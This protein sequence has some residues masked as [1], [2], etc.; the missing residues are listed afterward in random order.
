MYPQPGLAP[1][2]HPQP[3]FPQSHPPQ[4]Y[5]Q[6]YPQQ[7]AP[8]PRPGISSALSGA[9][10]LAWTGGAVTLLGVVLLLVLAA[11]RDWFT[12]PARIAAGALLAVALVAVGFWLYRRESAR[13]GAL[14][15]VATGFATAYLVVAAASALYGYL[16]AVPAL[17]IAL[18]VAG[19]GLG[20][21]DRWRTQLL[22]VAATVGAA[23]LAPVLAD[24]WLLVALVLALQV[25]ALPVVLRR[26]WSVL[27]LVAAAGPVVCGI[28]VIGIGVFGTVDRVVVVAVALAT[29]AVA[30]GTAVPAARLLPT[31]PVAALA[32]MAAVPTLVAAAVLGGWRGGA[33]AAVAALALAGLAFVP[34]IDRVIRIVAGAAASVALVQATAIALD[35][36]SLTLVVLGE[37]VVAAVLAAVLRS[38]FALVMAL[39]Y[40]LIGTL[41]AL[42]RDAPLAAL[43]RFPAYPYVVDGVT[44]VDALVTGVAVSALLLVLAGVL[45][46]AGGR[47]GWIR[48]D[49]STAGLWVPIGLAG[50]YGAAGIVIPLALLVSA[51]RAGFTAGHA[52]V[53]VSWTV[54]ALVLLARGI[55]RSALR[56]AGLV[57]VAAA[58]AKLVLF[59]LVALDGLARVGAFLGAGLVLLAAGSRYTRLAAEAERDRDAVPPQ[60]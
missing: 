38:R 20:V 39:A 34:G 41:A 28:V 16:G 17:F 14:A 8:A 50:L 7:A 53:T 37:A 6:S 60:E 19:A 51:D 10:L 26:K 44:R 43:V 59:D 35:G 3:H 47:L 45:L 48:P 18:L 13:T 58:V 46:A 9:R 55:S 5:P 15:L 2:S 32:G 42:G 33:L 54:A 31:A 29:L 36:S 27:M 56:I 4:F 24:G 52:L 23:V 21:A 12:P 57:L 49:A 22:A 25:A 30:L 1:P 11:S 40:G